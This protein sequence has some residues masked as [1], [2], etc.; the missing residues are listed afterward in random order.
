[1]EPELPEPPKPL[2]S[3]DSVSTEPAKRRVRYEV[4]TPNH[5]KRWLITAIVVLGGRALFAMIDDQGDTASATTTACIDAT[6][7]ADEMSALDTWLA[8][9]NHATEAHDAERVE[10][11]LRTMGGIY[12]SL[13]LIGAD[14][15]AIASR[16]RDSAAHLRAAADAMAAGNYVTA[17]GFIFAANADWKA[18]EEAVDASTVPA[19]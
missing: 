10:G 1:M 14:D 13:A 7:W 2:P 6:K 15:P 9:V 12:E 5:G 19:C 3:H 18:V 4:Q 11:D 8:E 16:I 17:N